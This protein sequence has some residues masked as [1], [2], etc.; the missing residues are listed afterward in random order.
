[1]SED[2]TAALAA[3]A[4][5]TLWRPQ[6]SARL[7][8]EPGMV[9]FL[10]SGDELIEVQAAM[11]L[12]IELSKSSRNGGAIPRL[13]WLA[14]LRRG[15][16][17]TR[18]MPHVRHDSVTLPL[19][20]PESAANRKPIKVSKVAAILGVDPKT[21]YRRVKD[22]PE[23]AL[24]VTSRQGEALRFNESLVRRYAAKYPKRGTAAHDQDTP[25]TE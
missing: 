20:E 9:M 22:H 13:S 14:E 25:A 7:I 11:A 21:I 10:F 2:V 1:M 18:S 24:A 5:T 17:L 6:A 16:A 15:A 8:A 19:D 12:L 23:L 3:A 4:D